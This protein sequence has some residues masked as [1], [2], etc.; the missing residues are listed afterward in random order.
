MRHWFNNNSERNPRRIGRQVMSFDHCPRTNGGSGHTPDLVGLIHAQSAEQIGLGLVP[1]R[2][3][4]GAGLFVNRHEAHELHQATDTLLVYQVFLVAQMPGHLPDT[5][6]RRFQ[7]LLI[8]LTHQH[9]YHLALRLIVKRGPQD[10]QQP[11][12]LTDGQIRI[13]GLPISVTTVSQ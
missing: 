4:V 3:P 8:D 2:S 6:K 10:R 12:L 13:G 1:L 11:A 9:Q 7:E 5:E